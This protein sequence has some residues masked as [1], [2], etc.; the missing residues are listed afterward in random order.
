MVLKR[1]VRPK[2]KESDAS[3][4]DTWEEYSNGVV[5]EVK[6]LLMDFRPEEYGDPGRLA[7]HLARVRKVLDEGIDRLREYDRDMPEERVSGAE[8]SE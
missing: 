4:K 2:P 5:H 8:G 1:M 7:D 3:A 6:N